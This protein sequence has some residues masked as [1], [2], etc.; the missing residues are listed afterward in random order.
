MEAEDEDTFVLRCA[1]CGTTE[2][3]AANLSSQTTLQTN[4]TVRCGHMFCNTCIEREFARRREFSCPICETPVKRVHLTI[5]SLDHV[6][7]E[8][9]T[10]WRRRVL[11]V[12]NKTEK[13]FATLLEYNN[14]LEE[15]EDK[16]YALVNEEPEAEEIKAQIKEYEQQHRAQIV[17]RQ[18]QKADEE[19]SI[20]DRI[21]AEQR[22]ADENRKASMEDK[23]AEVADK[24]RFKKEQV[25]VLL[26]KRDEV[27]AEARQAQMQ[28]YRSELR[29]QQQGKKAVANFVS[30]K[31]REPVD[32]LKKDKKIDHPT[33]LKRQQA[34][35]GLAVNNIASNERAWNETSS[36]LFATMMM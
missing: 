15:V 9:D 31:V 11:S 26:G 10:S 36:S 34:G 32:G 14:Y 27:S 13:D 25:E 12:Y 18:S 23:R 1:V 16:I 29:R 20:E 33:Y 22:L 35:G 19:R 28:G 30:P 7:C 4:A 24:K 21:A 8:K 17:I 6:Q 2:G 3:D 5:R